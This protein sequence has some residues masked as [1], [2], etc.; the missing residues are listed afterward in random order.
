MIAPADALTW[1]QEHPVEWLEMTFGFHYWQRQQEILR[2][3]KDHTITI[4]PSCN[5]SGK[6]F[7]AASAA[8]WALYTHPDSKVI[9]T[10][11]TWGQIEEAIWGEIRNAWDNAKKP[12]GGPKPNTVDLKLGPNWTLV[13]VSTNDPVALQ[14][15]HAHGGVWIIAEEGDGIDEKTFAAIKGNMTG[16]GCH[17]LVILNPIDPESYVA[18]NLMQD[19]RA[20]IL[21]IDAFCTPNFTEFGVQWDDLLTGAWKQKVNGAPLPQP[22]LITPEWA[23]AETANEGADSPFVVSRI[24]AR[25]PDVAEDALI[26]QSWIEKAWLRWK[27]G[28]PETGL[29]A[30]GHD[31]ARYGDDK[32][33]TAVRRGLKFWISDV[34]SQLDSEGAAQQAMRR[35]QLEFM[36]A[37]A[38]A[39]KPVIFTDVAGVGAGCFDILKKF[40]K[41]IGVDNA[42]KPDDPVLFVNKRAEMYWNFRELLRTEDVALDPADRQLAAELRAVK[43][44][45]V[46]N[47]VQIEEKAEIKKRLKR[48]PDRADAVV[49]AANAH[50]GVALGFL[51]AMKQR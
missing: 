9:T 8:L 3:F 48:S 49:L 6:T 33:V 24:K 22:W 21:P 18:R 1:A 39:K 14:G 50:S 36:N 26:Q 16:E 15:K 35:S 25:W 51:E 20:N 30:I 17:L 45:I 40:E 28:A 7:T 44:K 27:A 34:G 46:K 19:P 11:V 23:A 31:V 47:R 5:G 32:T 12:L 42:S 37:G 43:F 13:G 10:G 4:V 2:S 38:A 29:N 41:V